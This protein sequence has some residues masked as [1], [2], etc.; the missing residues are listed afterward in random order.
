LGHSLTRLAAVILISVIV[1][2]GSGSIVTTVR[3]QLVD[4]IGTSEYLLIVEMPDEVPRGEPINLTFMLVLERLP[5]LKHYSGYISLTF[6]LMSPDGRILARR[7]VTNKAEAYK[8]DY[9]YP[10]YRWG[11][12]TTSIL[13]DYAISA[14]DSIKVVVTLESEE[15]AEDPLGIPVI[16]TRPAPA[17]VE[18]GTVKI[19]SNRWSYVTPLLLIA[20]GLL[21]TSWIVLF[22]RTRYKRLRV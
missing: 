22:L 8:V 13:P 2:T 15:Y 9:I 21:L 4:A 18:I 14:S 20:I 5:P 3:I 11:P 12:F 19:T 1:N 6:T 17:V 16:P 10:G 7:T